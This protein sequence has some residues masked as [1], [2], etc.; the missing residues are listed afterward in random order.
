VCRPFFGAKFEKSFNRFLNLPDFS[1][2]SA[3]KEQ[4]RLNKARLTEGPGICDVCGELASDM[5][6][7]IAERHKV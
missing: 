6:T 1:S 2:R 3:H 4:K 7:H 5:A